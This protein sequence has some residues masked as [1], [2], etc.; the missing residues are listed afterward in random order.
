M[1]DLITNENRNLMDAA[2][3]EE[4]DFILLDEA[5]GEISSSGSEAA[6]KQIDALLNTLSPQ[7]RA[8]VCQYFGLEVGEAVFP[9]ERPMAAEQEM[10][11]PLVEQGMRRLR[12]SERYRDKAA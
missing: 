7:E 12:E 2:M 9:Q 5:A 11:P 1:H 3:A 6:R 10:L 4:G 8:V